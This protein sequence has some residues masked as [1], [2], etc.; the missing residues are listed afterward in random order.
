M[1]FLRYFL[2]NTMLCL[3]LQFWMPWWVI[4]PVSFAMAYLF[5]SSKWNAAWAGFVGIFLVW[6][7]MALISESRSDISIAQLL[8]SLL[9]NIPAFAA[10]ILTG[11]T[12]GICAGLGGLLGR[13][14]RELFSSK[15]A[16][17]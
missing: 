10:I 11:L 7:G 3:V 6:A 14:A 8:G 1:T 13:W 17:S 15:S 9:G 4:L 2:F 5:A 12:G 16:S